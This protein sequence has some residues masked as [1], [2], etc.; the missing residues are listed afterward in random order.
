MGKSTLASAPECYNSMDNCPG[1][2]GFNAETRLEIEN[3]AVE[4]HIA[5]AAKV[6]KSKAQSLTK[7]NVVFLGTMLAAAVLI[8]VGSHYAILNH[9]RNTRGYDAMKTFYIMETTIT[10]NGD[11]DIV[12][13][14]LLSTE[15]SGLYLFNSTCSTIGV[16]SYPPNTPEILK[17]V[18]QSAFLNVTLVT[19][20]VHLWLDKGEI[21]TENP[22]SQT[23]NYYLVFCLCF[24]AAFLF[25]TFA[26]IYAFCVS[27]H[28]DDKK[29]EIIRRGTLF[30][31]EYQGCPTVITWL[32]M[33]VFA[34]GVC[35]M[36]GVMRVYSGTG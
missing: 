18:T 10:N 24:T 19:A 27:C 15:S 32:I 33:S 34:I 13:V 9:N 31:S 29:H 35:I 14:S 7:Y 11:W 1:E 4:K 12:S 2:E 16:C 21:T 30:N 5:K 6:A 25:I 26:I 28:L 8:G 20:E 3:N 23:T 17:N 36:I 22:I